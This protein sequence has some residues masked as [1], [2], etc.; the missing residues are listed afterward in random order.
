MKRS[1]AKVF[2]LFGIVLML[3]ACVSQTTQDASKNKDSLDAK[4][5]LQTSQTLTIWDK[6]QVNP[7]Y[8]SYTEQPYYQEL[9]KRTGIKAEYRFPT[10]DLH[11]ES[12]NLMIAS[13]ELPDII[14]YDWLILP[15][16][17][18]KYVKEGYIVCINEALEKYAPNLTGYLLENPDID[19]MVKTDGGDYYCFPTLRGDETLNVY[20]GPI[21]R[22]D[23]LDELGLS[24]PET[25]DDWYAMLKAFKEK[26]G[27]SA[28]LSYVNQY[29]F[30]GGFLAG[31]FGTKLG[32]YQQSGV[33]HYGPYE[34]QWKDFLV[35]LRR[36]YKEG[37]IDA[38]I[39]TIDSKML[40]SRI[41]SGKT[42]AVL[43][44]GGNIGQW[45]PTLLSYEPSSS[46]IGVPYPVLNRGE[47]PMFSQLDN[48]YVFGGAA[49]TSQCKNIELA[50]R[51][52][53]YGYSEQGRMYHNFGI[54]GVSYNLVDDYPKY[55][56]AILGANDFMSEATKYINTEMSIQDPRMYE[57]R[58]KY[59]QQKEAILAW[60]KSDAVKYLIPPI[61]PTEEESGEM[62][63]MINDIDTAV[64]EYLLK[65][66]FGNES[67]A[68]F[69][70]Y[71]KGLERDGIKRVLELKQASLDRY[72]YR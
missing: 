5:P 62:T 49:I 27:A 65:F 66:V 68:T 44:S 59:P 26:K 67:E 51:Y 19:R 35:T 61:I 17:P 24:T 8:T 21:V 29:A 46:L 6:S 13:G 25:M 4:Y 14:N 70:D 54:E 56:D 55:S 58:L 40:A 7:A 63:R 39:A 23:W 28:P 57:Q 52:L 3:S 30:E 71:I 60:V 1:I 43:G 34:P 16:G 20:Q 53:D 11:R 45:L 33:I 37:L 69:D 72:N 31:S 22:S 18:E 48:S 47:T 50:A 41:T 36:W 9:E 32:F 12:F 38:D 15:G 42:G 2:P 10:G 64:R